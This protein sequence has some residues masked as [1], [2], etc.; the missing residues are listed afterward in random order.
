MDQPLALVVDDED[1]IRLLIQLTLEMEGYR[2]LAAPDGPTAL[3]LARLHNPDVITLDIMMPGM[4]GWE[5]AER[6]GRDGVTAGI[7]I[8]VVSG[9]PLIDLTT[10]PARHRAAAVL[11]KPFDFA[12][13][14]EI[15]AAARRP[16][17]PSL[18]LPRVSHHD[19]ADRTS[20]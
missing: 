5:V 19:A 1:S 4:D 7:P 11:S 3:E 20:H 17:K 9:K 6:L 13:F 8:V 18:P 10:N 15:V 14:V 12:A 2:T 16:R